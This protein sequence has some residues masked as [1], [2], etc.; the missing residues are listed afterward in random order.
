MKVSSIQL[1]IIDQSKQ[2]NLEH[3]IDMVDRAPESD[4]ILLPEI[5][6]CGFFLSTD[7]DL[8]ANRWMAPRSMHSKKRPVSENAIF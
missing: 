4:L 7:I 5:W 8:T 1:E 2:K 6:P 3:A